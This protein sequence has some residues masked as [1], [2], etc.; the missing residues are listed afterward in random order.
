MKKTWFITGASRGFGRIWAEAA[1][2]RG[3][4]VTATARKVADLA[5]LKKQFGDAVLTLALDVTHPEQVEQAVPQAYAH[6][7][8]LDVLVNNAGASLFAATEE[9]SDEQILDLFDANYLGMI[10]VLR[11]VLPLLRQQG[12]GHI[13]GV[14]SGLGITAM[15][16]LGFYSA[17]K[18]AVEALHEALAQEVRPFG[19]RVTLVE[20]GAYATDFGKSSK[21]AD[22]LGPYVDSR[23]QFLT[24]LASMESGDPEATAEAVLK[25]VDTENPPLRLGLGNTILPRARAAYAERLATWEAWEEVSNAAMG[26]PKKPTREWIEMLTHGAPDSN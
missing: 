26:E 11:A 3:D 7:G 6:F 5:D 18:W 10:R 22:A 21:I 1:L 9:A 23:K 25:L 13:L 19:L 2:K 15:P 24:R 4:N 16:L 20:P 17:T 8:R 12:S 14:S